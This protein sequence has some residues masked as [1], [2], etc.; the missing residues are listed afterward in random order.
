MSS[1]LLSPPHQ[2]DLAQTPHWPVP[3]HTHLQLRDCQYL[4]HKEPLHRF[5]CQK[6]PLPQA[7]PRSSYFNPR[8][9]CLFQVP[10]AHLQPVLSFQGSLMI[11]S[12]RPLLSGMHLGCHTA[13]PSFSS[14][15]PSSGNPGKLRAQ[16]CPKTECSALGWLQI[17]NT[18]NRVL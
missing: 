6:F 11:D 8:S 13:R 3:T 12:H 10:S 1:P 15:F 9:S 14:A 5:Q 16:N 4:W 2:Q 7:T 18:V 17:K